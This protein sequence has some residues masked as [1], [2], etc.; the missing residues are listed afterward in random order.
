MLTTR[1]QRIIS[2]KKL[3]PK[4]QEVIFDD[5]FISLLSDDEICKKHGWTLSDLNPKRD[6]MIRSL[7]AVT[8]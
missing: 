5:S 2:A 3:L 4:D 8:L 6:A 1:L 7:R